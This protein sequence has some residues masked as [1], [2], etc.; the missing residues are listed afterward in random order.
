M[1]KAKDILIEAKHKAKIKMIRD[2]YG[3]ALLYKNVEKNTVN[4]YPSLKF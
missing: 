4:V 1:A 3:N 2:I